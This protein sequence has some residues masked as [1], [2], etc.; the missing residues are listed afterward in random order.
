MAKFNY[1]EMY[2]SV[3]TSEIGQK[4]VNTVA[5]REFEAKKREMIE[6]F[7]A[8]PVTKEIEAGPGTANLS[9]TL[10]G[11]GDLFSFL[12]FDS[13]AEPTEPLREVLQ[14]EVVLTN[15]TSV[16]A[17]TDKVT[18]KFSVRIPTE[19]IKKATPMEWEKGL[20]WAEGIERGVS[21]FSN[22]LRGFF[23]TSRSGGG[24]QTE[25]QVRATSFKPRT[26]L[27]EILADFLKS[28]K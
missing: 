12:G 20:S 4:R 27:T 24:I 18:Y 7:D 17:K 19:S 15:S 14:N 8:H 10:G 1:K 5:R 11:E 21:G 16:E 9:N 28:F 13:E 26:Y 25:N 3:A 23:G 2:K 22:F 6:A